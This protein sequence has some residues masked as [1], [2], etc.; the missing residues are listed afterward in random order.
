MCRCSWYPLGTRPQ[1]QKCLPPTYLQ[2]LFVTGVKFHPTLTTLQCYT[3]PF[4][5]NVESY[6]L[7][8]FPPVLEFSR[9]K[10]ISSDSVQERKTP[11]KTP[12]PKQSFTNTE[13]PKICQEVC[14]IRSWKP[15]LCTGTPFLYWCTIFFLSQADQC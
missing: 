5:P 12:P 4:F 2:Q 8:L 14:R 7:N 10:H 3:C 1:L 6:T 11:A 9:N 15:D 13:Y